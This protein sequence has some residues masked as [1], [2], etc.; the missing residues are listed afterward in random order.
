V[1]LPHVLIV[2]DD[3]EVAELVT[4]GLGREYVCEQAAEAR[5]ALQLAARTPPAAV[6][7]DLR[8]RGG[9]GLDLLA[10]MRR[11]PALARV[12]VV[13]FSSSAD[14]PAVGR[15][16]AALPAAGPVARVPKSAGMRGVRTAL[17]EL[18]RKA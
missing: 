3:P 2:E 17:A 12:P 6:V 1:K 4:L 7:L 16:L 11:H 15:R 13:I 10:A 14:Q 5:T 18:L 9:D 8:L